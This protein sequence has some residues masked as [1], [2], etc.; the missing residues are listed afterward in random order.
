MTNSAEKSLSRFSGS[1]FHLQ[2]RN[3]GID[4]YDR[5]IITQTTV[6]FFVN[7]FVFFFLSKLIFRGISSTHLGFRIIRHSHD[8]PGVLVPIKCNRRS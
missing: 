7:F 8:R 1:G 6:Y 4:E 3:R 2:I 5:K